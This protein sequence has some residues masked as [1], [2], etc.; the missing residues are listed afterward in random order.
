MLSWISWFRGQA[1]APLCT[2]KRFF[3]FWSGCPLARPSRVRGEKRLTPAASEH[4][5]N[6]KAAVTDPRRPRP[7]S[8]PISVA[9]GADNQAR[10][11]AP[12]CGRRV[13]GRIGDHWTPPR[14]GRWAEAFCR[15]E[16]RVDAAKQAGGWRLPDAVANAT[17]SSVADAD[18]RK[19][20]NRLGACP[21]PRRRT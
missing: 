21:A 7:P 12:P 2:R 8:R 20:R 16:Y 19:S 5:T 9:S 10:R 6:R 15:T 11:V 18:P 14:F 13:S 1:L 3:R 4:K 17:D